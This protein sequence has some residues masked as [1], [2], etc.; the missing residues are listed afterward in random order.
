MDQQKR[1]LHSKNLEKT[2]EL[3]ESYFE[4][5]FCQILDWVKLNYNHDLSTNFYSE[6]NLEKLFGD[7]KL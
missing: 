6:K 7:S 5:K 4:T 1:E 3:L 2:K